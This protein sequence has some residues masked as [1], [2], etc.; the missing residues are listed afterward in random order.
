MGPMDTVPACKQ[1]AAIRRYFCVHTFFCSF[2]R[3]FYDKIDTRYTGR[4]FGD[5][6]TGSEESMRSRRRKRRSFVPLFAV[7][8]I[9][10]LIMGAVAGFVIGRRYMPGKEM[11]D[12]AELFHIKGS[13]VAVLLNNELQEEKGIYEDGQVYLPVS[14]VNECVNE[15][16]YWDETEKLL[17]YALPEE[18]VYADESDVGERGPLL[19][20]KEG[21]AYL[22]LGLILNYSDIR[23]QSFD[24]SEIKRVFI[25]TVWEP[26]KTAQIRRKSILREKGGIKSD[27][28]TDLSEGSSVQV[29]ETMDKW[30]KVRTEDGYI[31]YVQN[32][33]LEKEQEITPQ[34]QFKAPVYTSISMDEKVRLGFHQVTRKEANSTL[35]EY[36]QTAEGMNVIVPTWFNVTGNDGAYTSLASRDYVKQAHD[37]GLKVWAMVENVSTKESVK[38]LDT[39]KLMSVTSNRKR[40][41]ESLMKEADIYGFDGFNL[42]FESLKAEAGPHYVQFIREMS[43][44]CR[45]KGLVL[46]VDNYVPSAYTAFYNRKEQ[47]II[48]DYVIVMGYDEHYAGGEAGPVASLPYV[49]KGIA[50]TLKEVPKEKVI[51]SIPFYTRIWTDKDGKTTSKAY[52]I[53]DAEKWIEE[54]NIELEWQDDLGVY[55]G[56]KSDENGVQSV[57]M[58]EERS[59][60]LKIDRI[61]EYGL[62]GVACWK[63]G[64]EERSVWEI[65]SQV[66]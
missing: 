1:A 44:A 43:A 11:A 30:S 29:L 59:L 52:G 62:A 32:R 16:F 7:V 41:I 12:K 26:V 8:F 51:N 42:D 54:N 49:E 64:F 19:K 24:S 4:P 17:V 23:Q 57:W 33:R 35:K 28:I 38:E 48:A 50:D 63:L 56:Q 58:E 39:K 40:L 15:R 13:Q 20:V 61:N 5:A 37:M 6:H 46:S 27:I 60:G 47:G 31:G 55:Y 53:R 36:A 2:F 65:V 14:W 3:R 18:I 25:D 9:L 66:K 10:L 34:S 45:K 22:S 21:E